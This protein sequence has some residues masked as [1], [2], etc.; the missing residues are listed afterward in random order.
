MNNYGIRITIEHVPFATCRSGDVT[1][2]AELVREAL[3]NF[4]YSIDRKMLDVSEHAPSMDRG[5][6]D[7]EI[8]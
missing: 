5:I 4:G 7:V 2:M 3:A 8:D 6:L 1:R